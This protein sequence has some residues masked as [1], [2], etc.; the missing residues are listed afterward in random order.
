VSMSDSSYFDGIIEALGSTLTRLPLFQ[1]QGGS[2]FEVI[3]AKWPS[4]PTGNGVICA[5][6]TLAEFPHGTKFFPIDFI[7]QCTLLVAE[8]IPKESEYNSSAY[9]LC[10]YDDD[11]RE[12]I[13]KGFVFGPNLIPN[14]PTEPDGKRPFVEYPRNCQIRLSEKGRHAADVFELTCDLGP[15]ILEAVRDDLIDARYTDA[16]RRAS[17]LLESR[18]RT[19]SGTEL[20]GQALVDK[21]FG[22]TGCLLP[23]AKCTLVYALEVRAMYRRFFKYIRNEVA[24]GEPFFHLTEACRLL[25]RCS[26]LVDVTDRL[27]HEKKARER[28]TGTK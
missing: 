4:Y 24:H 26:V 9:H 6:S 19:A 23:Q 27:A 17:V 21:C 11:I 13:R 20:Y 28:D 10:L 25:R 16:V 3:H 12:M 7:D 22:S 5:V 14:D 2:S 8:Q 1:D 18:L 15:D